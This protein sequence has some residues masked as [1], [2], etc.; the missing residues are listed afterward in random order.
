[1][2]ELPELEAL[3]HFL[4]RQS[5]GRHLTRLE[6]ASLSALK[7]VRPG[8]QDLVGR[9]VEGWERRGKYLCL[10]AEHDF[11]VLHLARGGW[12]HWSDRLSQVVAR[13]TRG[14]LTLRVGLESLG[15]SEGAPGFEVTEMG[16]EKRV[17]LWVVEQ[18][19]RVGP[20]ALLGPDALD[21]NLDSQALAG[22]LE[23]ARGTIK[24]ALTT[25]SLIAGVGNAY[26]DEVLHLARLSPFRA[27]A[28]LSGLEVAELH[29]CLVERLGE[30]VAL[31]SRLQPDRLKPEKHT[32]M[33]VH[34]R[35]GLPCPQCG[36]TIRQVAFATR[37]LQYC[38]RCQTRG[39]VLS[40]R[41]LSRLLK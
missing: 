38:P 34:G 35:T 8:L 25:Q 10:R 26:S 37:S 13:P 22:I 28:S 11:L 5:R 4:D 17:A 7:T 36:D 1:M 15:G 27:A 16:S 29:R 41:R 2:P 33:R 20:V 9:R 30:A 21:P 39:R 14:P 12:V 31:A 40:D 23:R 32:A 6:L 18:P 3:A 24:T 19:E